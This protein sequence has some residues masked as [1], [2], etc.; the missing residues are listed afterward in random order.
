M[1]GGW[2]IK[3]LGDVC[4]L[5]RGFDLPKRLR[6]SGQYP[7][8][9]SSGEIDSHIEAKVQAPGVATGRSGSIGNVFLI[10]KDFWPLNTVLYVKDFHDNDE[11]FVYHLLKKF[12]LKRYASG[13][14]VPTLNRNNVHDVEVCVPASREEQQRI[15][16]I[17]DDVFEGIDAATA[18][19]EQNLKHTREL[20]ESYLQS[21][22]KDKGEGWTERTLGDVCDIKHGFAFKGKDF[23]ND[24]DQ[25]KPIVIT[26]GNFTETATLNFSEKN[27]K[28]FFGAVA[29]E[30]FLF[31]VGDLVIVMTD[32]S[33]KMKILGKPAFIDRS[34][35]LHNQR[36]GRLMFSESCLNKKFLYYFLQTKQFLD[37]IKDTA[38]GTMV[39]HTAPKRILNA[40]VPFPI[41]LEEQQRIVELLDTLVSETQ[42]L[43]AIYQKKLDA[44]AEL[45]QSLLQK[46][47]AGE[48]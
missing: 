47:F 25:S 5:Q 37:G 15:V 43:E 28:R 1:R 9:S 24:N 3:R 23:A 16:A 33:S 11:R 29:P 38:T 20:L 4:T 39:K 22:F 21:V 35:I 36:I 8:I 48:L 27:T 41:E 6:E 17:L 31:D 46:A 19:A 30:D 2:E 32:L 10:E 45:R 7:L 14:G 34:N 26:P 18:N 12:D 13:A 42:L 44:L 40:N